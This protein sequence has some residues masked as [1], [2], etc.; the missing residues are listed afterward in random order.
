MSFDYERWKEAQLNGM[1]QD[2]T[3]GSAFP[4]SIWWAGMIWS[5]TGVFALLTVAILS[6]QTGTLRTPGSVLGGLLFLYGGVRATTGT[7]P[8]TLRTGIASI[9]LGIAWIAAGVLMTN[10]G[11]GA[12]GMQLLLSGVMGGALILAGFLALSGRSSYRAW[13]AAHAGGGSR[14]GGNR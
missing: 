4:N 9:A 13:R 12:N 10:L 11:L 5:A 1:E 7:T 2:T 3:S 8:D 6:L 14:F